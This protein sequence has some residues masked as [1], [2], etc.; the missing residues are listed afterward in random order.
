MQRLQ[1]GREYVKEALARAPKSE[2]LIKNL[3]YFDKAL[4][5][6]GGNGNI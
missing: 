3:A 1:E 6:G 4:K 5:E 2:Q